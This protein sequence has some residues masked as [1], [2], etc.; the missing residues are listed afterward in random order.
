M[1]TTLQP[2]QAFP[3]ALSHQLRA[4]CRVLLFTGAGMSAESGVPTFRDAQ[5]GLWARFD[6][7]QLASPEGF[8]A[9]PQRVWRWYQ[10]RHELIN[11]VTPNP[12][13][14]ALARWQRQRPGSL[15]VTQ[16]VDGLH[17]RAG[18]DPVVALHGDINRTVC[19][20]T[21]RPIT[22]A[23]LARH[24]GSEPPPSPHHPDGLAR[25]DVVWFGEALDAALLDRAFEFADRADLVV[26]VGT[27]G[28]VQPAASIPIQACRRGVPM[29]EINPSPSELS[30]WSEWRLAGSAAACLPGLVDHLLDPS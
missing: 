20:H 3:A 17:Q 15:L 22:R 28:L 29:V 21:G 4:S 18:S 30:R 16:N 14:H 13:H 26:V 12:G 9:D 19:S 7:M 27:A 2:D 24:A 23:W 5:Q 10:W 1:T 6:P 25:P 8:A 11:R